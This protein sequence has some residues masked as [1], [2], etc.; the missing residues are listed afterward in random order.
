MFEGIKKAF[1]FLYN[2]LID[3]F[4]FIVEAVQAIFQPIIDI[5]IGIGYFIYKIGVVLY[6]VL[7]VLGS[8]G[9]L[10]L[11]LIQGLYRTI[12]SFDYD[13]TAVNLPGSIGQA[14]QNLQPIFQTLQFNKIGYVVMFSIWLFTALAAVKIIQTFR[15]G[16]DA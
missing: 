13:G 16:N 4:T 7:S 1:E 15:G 9:K 10:V 8:V 12:L 14:F 2:L 3:L 11:G 5:F 6:E